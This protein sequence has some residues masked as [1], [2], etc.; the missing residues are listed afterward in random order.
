[1]V[2]SI[3]L[4]LIVP[5]FFLA[6]ETESNEIMP[7]TVFENEYA[8]VSHVTLETGQQQPSHYGED[9][10]IYSLNDYTIGFQ[11]DEMEVEEHQL[12]EDD[13][14]F[15]ESGEHYSR[16]TGEETAE[17]LVFERKTDDLPQAD[18]LE[19]D[20]EEDLNLNKSTTVLFEN[21]LFKA[22]KV[23]VEPGMEIPEHEGSNRVV[24]SLSN[25]TVDFDSEAEAEED[26]VTEFEIGDVHWHQAA[27]HSVEISGN[28]LAEF[29]IVVYKTN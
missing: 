9:R 25:Y 5:L 17:W 24:Y 11:Q 29:L 22:T 4:F 3:V 28:T 8:K 26:R 23:R 10:I 15:H 7:E 18:D 19:T 14:H 20:I 27:E 2:R 1:M 16:N 13:V 6:C 12:N 21:E